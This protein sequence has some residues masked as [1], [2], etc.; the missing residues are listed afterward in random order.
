METILI[1]VMVFISIALV[2]FAVVMAIDL[3]KLIDAEARA[4][5]EQ[6]RAIQKSIFK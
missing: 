3:N 1:F 6:K 5:L 2:L 4:E